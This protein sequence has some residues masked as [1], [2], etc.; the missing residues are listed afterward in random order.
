MCL[1]GRFCQI[2]AKSAVT[3]TSLLLCP[4]FASCDTPSMC[5][6]STFCQI[7]SH[8]NSAPHAY[9]YLLVLAVWLHYLPDL[10]CL[11]H[12]ALSKP[13]TPAG[14]QIWATVPCAAQKTDAPKLCLL[15][16]MCMTYE[17][18]LCVQYEELK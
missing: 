14:C 1:R 13:G 17:T 4:S 3:C 6:K 15:H 16:V 8:A 2:S 9:D 12:L 5:M 18:S 7:W 10:A 11:F